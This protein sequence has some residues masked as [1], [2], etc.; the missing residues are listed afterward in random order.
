[1]SLRTYLREAVT[2]LH[3]VAWPTR[4]QAVRISA[5]V[6]GVTFF[7]AFTFG[8]FDKALSAGYLYLLNLAQAF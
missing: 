7:F 5:I 3:K 1:M 2:E 8:L 4:A 6:L